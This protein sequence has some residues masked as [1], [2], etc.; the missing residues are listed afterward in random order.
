MAESQRSSVG[1]SLIKAEAMEKATSHDGTQ[2][3]YYRRGVGAPLVLVHGTGAADPTAWPAFPTLEK[4]FGVITVDRRGR[5]ESGDGSPYAIEREFEDI[6]V[7][8]DAIGESVNVLG[9][10]FGGLLALEA[11]RLSRNI[12]KLVLYEGVPISGEAF[13]EGTI[14]RLQALL[15]TG[16][17]T[18]VLTTHYRDIGGLSPNQIEQLRSSPAWPAR[19]AS[20]H[21]VPRELRALERYEFDPDRFKDLQTPTLLLVGGDS[22]QFVRDATETVGEALPN[23]QVVVL[24]GQQHIAMYTAPDQF[25][26]TVVRFLLELQ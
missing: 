25:A 19:L 2:I 12:H 1:N 6:A 15:D 26:S 10:S 13:P 14:D 3:A 7:V 24:P 17:R 9:H 16:D 21:T 23:S 18:G 11:A 5:G 22:P 8:V 4:H 20:A